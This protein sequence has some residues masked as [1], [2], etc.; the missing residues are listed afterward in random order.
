MK[1]DLRVKYNDPDYYKNL[2]RVG[3]LKGDKRAGAKTAKERYGD[4]YHSNIAT[5]KVKKYGRVK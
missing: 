1:V 5:G 4:D 3:G 2:G